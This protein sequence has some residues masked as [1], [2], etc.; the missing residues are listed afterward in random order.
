MDKNSNKKATIIKYTILLLMLFFLCLLF[1]YTGDD[2]AWGSS[3]GLN[4]LATR[5]DN[6]S[7]R[8]L[9]NLIVLALTRSRLLRSTVMSLTL[10]VTVYC[11]ERITKRSWAFYTASVS[12]LLLPR[13]IFRQ[14]IVWTAGFSNYATS[15][16]LTLIFF[17]YLTEHPATGEAPKKPI[18][19]LP[20]L[21]LLGAANTLIV[22]HLTVFHV[23]LS[24]LLAIYISA[25][26]K[27]PAPD[28]ISYAIGC[29]SGAALMFSN[30]VYHS[31]AQ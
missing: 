26:R 4:R 5:F 11:I 16:C 8:Y 30:S 2:W 21:L 17:V 1:P 24:V 13:T 28:Y 15:L 29:I 3:I 25:R 7:G 12:L 27:A 31:I 10:T 9:G 22:E 20:G 23:G 14:S 18:L 6:Y 19:Q